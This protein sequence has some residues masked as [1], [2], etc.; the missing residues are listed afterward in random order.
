MPK[1]MTRQEQL[2]ELLRQTRER[3]WGDLKREFGRLGEDYRGEFDRAM[4]AGDSSVVDLVQ[5]IGVKLV[6]IRQSEITQLAEA[7]RKLNAGTYG[8]CDDCGNEISEER[9]RAVP[10]AIRCVDCE[11]KV[12]KPEIAG[13]GPTL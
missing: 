3:L 6:D 5:S 4:D 9:L 13:K 12:E 7:E 2:R 10:Y 8:I 11:K 1:K